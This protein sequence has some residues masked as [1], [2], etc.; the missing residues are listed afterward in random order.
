MERLRR[1]YHEAHLMSLGNDIPEGGRVQRGWNQLVGASYE[2]RIYAFRFATTEKQ[3]QFKT[4]NIPLIG[5]NRRA[6]SLCFPPSPGAGQ[7]SFGQ[8]R[9]RIRPSLWRQYPTV[10]ALFLWNSA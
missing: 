7:Q 6:P 2:R 8:G 10:L 1:Q 9:G 4:F 3:G 5:E